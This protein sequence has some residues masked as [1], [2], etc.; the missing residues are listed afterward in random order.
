MAITRAEAAVAHAQMTAE[1]RRMLAGAAQGGPAPNMYGIASRFYAQLGNDSRITY[2]DYVR[3]AARAI[4]AVEA[5][6]AMRGN[7]QVPQRLGD[8]PFN[9]GINFPAQVIEYR[10]VL[11][12]LT[13]NANNPRNEGLIIIR[14]RVPMTLAALEAEARRIAEQT[15][16]GRGYETRIP[17]LGGAAALGVVVV[18]VSRYEAP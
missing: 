18:A 9:Y 7:P 3:V 15:G 17:T 14:S 8:I 2:Q 12:G 1:V 5:A 11:T 16:G 6:R 10:V 4:A 13:T